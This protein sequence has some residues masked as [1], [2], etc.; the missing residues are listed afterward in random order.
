MHWALKQLPLSSFKGADLK[1]IASLPSEGGTGGL[2]CRC[3]AGGGLAP[4]FASVGR[5]GWVV[6]GTGRAMVFWALMKVQRVYFEMA[7]AGR[8]GLVHSKQRKW[9]GAGG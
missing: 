7:G 4:H 3:L 9:L 1:P 6:N 5:R 2:S 8:A